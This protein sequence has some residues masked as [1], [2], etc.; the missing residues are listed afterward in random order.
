MIPH[1]FVAVL[2]VPMVN[3]NVS[4]MIQSCMTMNKVVQFGGD[5][6]SFW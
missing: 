6:S 2:A 1:A 3:N 5:I 4:K